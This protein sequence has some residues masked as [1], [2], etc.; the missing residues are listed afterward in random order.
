MSS[1]PDPAQW[2]CDTGQW[3][4][5]FDRCQLT[6]TCTCISNIKD[7]HRK[8]RLQDVVLR[9]HSHYVG[10]HLQS[11]LLAMFTTRKEYLHDFFSLCLP[12]ILFLWLRGFTSWSFGPPE[13]WYEYNYANKIVLFS[14]YQSKKRCSK[15]LFIWQLKPRA[16]KSCIKH[17]LTNNN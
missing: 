13:L 6:I 17:Q 10:Q 1:K 14:A 2:S 3:I 4:P 5:C 7:I 15:R 12:V 9:E 11:M 16:I 8:P